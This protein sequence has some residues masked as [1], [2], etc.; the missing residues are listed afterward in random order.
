M[1]S[2]PFHSTSNHIK[3]GLCNSTQGDANTAEPDIEKTGGQPGPAHSKKINLAILDAVGADR[4]KSG[5]AELDQSELM[6]FATNMGIECTESEI[7]AVF[8][9]CNKDASAQARG[10]DG[11]VGGEKDQCML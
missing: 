11:W 6:Q 8:T 7:Q 3:M 9:S 10:G 4:L 2:L 1:Q 5:D